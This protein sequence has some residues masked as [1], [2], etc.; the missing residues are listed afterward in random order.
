MSG[1]FYKRRRGIL[2]H[3]EA[4]RLSLLDSGV[5]DYLCLNANQIVGNGSLTPPGEVRTSAAAIAAGCPRQY[6]PERAI[7]RSLERLEKIGFIK[8]CLKQVT[9]FPEH[10]SI[11]S[12]KNMMKGLFYFRK[13]FLF[14]KMTHLNH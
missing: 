1:G 12:M 14:L 2:E 11:L 10:R 7:R 3:L 4:G 5:H 9:K 8:R 6:S 13:K